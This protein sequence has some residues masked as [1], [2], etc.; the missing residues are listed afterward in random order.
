MS[1][2]LFPRARGGRFAGGFL[3]LTTALAAMPGTIPAPVSPE[4]LEFFEAKIRPILADACYKCHSAEAGKSKGDLFLDSRAGLLKGGAGGPAIVAGDPDKSLLIEA[5]RYTDEDLQMPPKNDGGKLAPEQIALLEQWVKMGAPDPRTGGK[6]HPLD[7]AAARQ[8]WAFQPV[9]KPEVPAVPPALA[10]RVATPVDAFVFATQAAKGLAPAPAADARTLVRRVT[11]DL[12]GLPPTAE[13][14]ETFVREHAA[15]PGAYGRLVDRLLASPRYG[16]RWGRFWLD[17]ARYADTKGY[18]AGNAERRYAF[19]HTYRDYVIRAFNEDKPYDR[20]LVE[21]LAADRLPLG[22]DKSALAALGFLTLGRRFLNNQNDIIDDRID[23]VTRGTMALTVTCARCHDHKFDPVPI[24]DYYSLHGVFASSE[25]PEEKPLLGPQV[26]SPAYREFL[27]KKA[28]AEAKVQER[29]R[30]EVAKFLSGLRTKTGDYLLGAHD[31]ARLG[32]NEKFDLFAG[33]RKLNPEVLRRWQASLA[34]GAKAAATDP[35]LAPWLALAALP[36]GE[37]ATRGPALVATWAGEPAINPALV[38]AFAAADQPLAAL[39]DAAAVYNRVFVALDKAMAAGGEAAP[40]ADPGQEALRRWLLADGAPTNLGYDTAARMIKR[41]I[42]DKTSGLRREVEALNWT[43]PGA[44]LRAMALADRPQPRN[45]NVFLRGNPANRGP[46]APRRFL[47]IL[48]GEARANFRDGSGRLE[49]ARAIASADNPL[50]ARVFV[51]RVWGWHFGTPLVRTASDFGVRTEAPVQH[52]LLDWLA[53]TFVES[54]WSVKGLHRAIVLSS[55]YRQTSD[56]PAAV[57]ADPDNQYL[58]RF[59]R[60]RLEFE[61]LRDTLLAVSGRLDLRTGGLPDDL[62]AEPFTA[63]RTVYG[64]IDRQ[65]LP[66]M[67]RTFDYPNPDV[68]SA[69]RF[70]TT[71][72]Q[73]ALFLLNSPF[74]VEQARHALARAEV[75]AASDPAAKVDALYRAVLQR[76][77]DAEERALALA[78]VNR[79]AAR[80]SDV[81][82]SAGWR[83]GYGRFDAASGRVR[84]FHALIERRDGKLYPAA[85]FP[86]AKFGH[87]MMTADGGHP[88]KTG[89]YSAVRRWV[90]PADGEVKIEGVLGH[91]RADGDG[92]RARIVS[93]AA[94][95]RGEW[96]VHNTKAETK[97]AAL[98]VKAGDTIDFVVDAIASATAD[99]FT[100]APKVVFSPGADGGEARTWDAKKDFNV[101]PKAPP[102]LLTPWEEFAQVLLLSNELAFVD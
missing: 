1:P 8:H 7:M 78:F 23:V 68:S 66:G 44:P 11:F 102:P 91:A 84:E 35:V 53:A 81:T 59:Q 34:A 100:W 49:L 72:P 65:N 74:V 63:R 51:N 21:Q 60:R 90:A 97:P 56:L 73:Q 95:V 92:V 93:S 5:V 70:A 29:A 64:F 18:L 94:G 3:A 77:P 76:R 37:F 6:P 75:K 41:Q 33:A 28:A 47:E 85:K 80:T 14:T 25:E 88:G 9:R 46:E 61:A 27:K 39:K 99:T 32:K 67:F 62:V 17:V 89:E 36:E 87:L 45:S 26:D 40:L 42:D 58:T 69:G 43:E 15:D 71:V 57:T 16:E 38:A 12:T 31:A 50:T 20:F 4:Q 22:E 83:Y 30:S 48:G 54:G 96:K 19:S 24:K 82:E 2:S 55:T 13:E 79:P 10:R 101:A 52:A 98:A 86:D